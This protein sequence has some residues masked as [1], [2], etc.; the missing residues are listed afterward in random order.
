MI[1][2]TFGH[3]PQGG[4]QGSTGRGALSRSTATALVPSISNLQSFLQVHL[5]DFPV[6]NTQFFVLTHVSQS[7]IGVEVLPTL[8]VSR[9]EGHIGLSAVVQVPRRVERGDTRGVHPVEEAL[10]RAPLAVFVVGQRREK[11]AHQGLNWDGEPLHLHLGELNHDL[12]AREVCVARPEGVRSGGYIPHGNHP[13]AFHSTGAQT[14]P[15]AALKV[16]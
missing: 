7:H 12:R 3:G 15:R 9:S 2:G 16:L 1:Q 10:G 5:P 8:Q 14:D 13:D 4:C 11:G 6:I